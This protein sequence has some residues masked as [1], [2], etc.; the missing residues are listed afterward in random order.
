M[1]KLILSFG[2][3]AGFALSSF[4][5][6]KV[7]LSKSTLE[8]S[9]TKVTGS[10]KGTIGISSGNFAVTNKKLTGGTFELDVAA[11]TVTDVKDAEMNGKLTG[12]LKSADF[13]A[14]DKFPK[15][16]FVI[17]SVE[18]KDGNNCNI[19]GNLT[20]KRITNPVTFPATVKIDGNILISI[21]VITV[22]RTKYDIKFRSANFFENLGDKA[23]SDDFSLMVKL[24]AM[25]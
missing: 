24:V 10:H 18:N 9:A 19:T 13:F 5:Q 21:A 4:G 11:L 8:W 25:Q 2:F 15:A 23:I 14:T 7:D 16:T 20:I 12:H 17:T 1:K 3:I 6:Y 22:N